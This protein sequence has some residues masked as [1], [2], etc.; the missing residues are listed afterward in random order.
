MLERNLVNFQIWDIRE[1]GEAIDR[2]PKYY[3][4]DDKKLEAMQKL[5]KQMQTDILQAKI[6]KLG[7]VYV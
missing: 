5:A 4:V 3:A 6:K 2:K 7:K 1:D